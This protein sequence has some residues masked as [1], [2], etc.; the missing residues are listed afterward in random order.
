M[1][2]HC[3]VWRIVI[4]V[5][6]FDSSFITNAMNVEILSFEVFHISWHL[7]PMTKIFKYYHI[8]F[9]NKLFIVM[10]SNQEFFSVIVNKKYFNK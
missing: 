6:C 9:K 1:G 7:Y 5:E 10:L 4:N 2:T 8:E 3:K